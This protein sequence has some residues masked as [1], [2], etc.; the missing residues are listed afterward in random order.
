MVRRLGCEV[1]VRDGAG[2]SADLRED[3]PEG[4]AVPADLA[5]QE[6]T[7]PPE[8]GDLLDGS[9]LGDPSR[10]EPDEDAPA[11]RPERRRRWYVLGGVAALVVVL[12]A[13]SGPGWWR[14]VTQQHASLATP[15]QIAGLTLDK[16][17][18]GKVTADYLR[19]A[20]AASVSLNNSVGA[21]YDDPAD[22]RRSVM[23]FGGTG[24]L[25]SPDKDLT[26]AFGLLDDQSGRLR[27]VRSVPSGT[28]GGEMRCGTSTGDGGDMVVC[29][30]ADHGSIALA[31]F[32]GR[33]VDDAATLMRQIR[34]GVQHRG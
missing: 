6:E 20:I 13:V 22:S 14:L 4:V 8:D 34:D 19:T 7:D 30:W 27:D 5:P 25:L 9:L 15:D 10:Y 33:S 21:V 23:F 3:L 2:T 29:G 24:V 26:T 17:D 16:S 32:P 1:D 11:E 31:F 28:L 18:D 12:V